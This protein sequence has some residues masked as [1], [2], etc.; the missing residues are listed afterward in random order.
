MRPLLAITV[1]T[2]VEAV[3]MTVWLELLGFALPPLLSERGIIAAVVFVLGLEV[4]HVLAFNVG[5][6]RPLFSI[7]R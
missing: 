4:E 5:T 7:P 2:I 3:V 6:G 1:F